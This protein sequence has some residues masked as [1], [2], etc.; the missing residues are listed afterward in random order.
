MLE[1]G[2]KTRPRQSILVAVSP[3]EDSDDR[4]RLGLGEHVAFELLST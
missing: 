4:F 1:T 2:L 3:L